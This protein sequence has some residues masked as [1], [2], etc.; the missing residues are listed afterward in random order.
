MKDFKKQ[1]LALSLIGLFLVLFGI[2]FFV[3]QVNKQIDHTNTK[4]LIEKIG[5]TAREI[6]QEFDKGYS[7]DSLNNEG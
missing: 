7:V 3:Y 2:G 4:S 5:E 6:K 1:M